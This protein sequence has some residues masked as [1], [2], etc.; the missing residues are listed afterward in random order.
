MSELGIVE[1]HDECNEGGL[2]L[3]GLT[4]DSNVVS[5]VDFEVKALENPLLET[6]WVPEPNI[7]EFDF[8][9][10]L[11]HIN[12]LSGAFFVNDSFNIIF[13]SNSV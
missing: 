12:N 7:F 4:N 10:E 6:R 8:A 3:A 1:S 13:T 11:S 2:A 5:G 9:F